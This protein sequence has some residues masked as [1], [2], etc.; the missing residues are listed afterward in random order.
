MTMTPFRGIYSLIPPQ[1][2]KKKYKP[3]LS[4]RLFKFIQ[5]AQDSVQRGIFLKTE[6]N[7]QVLLDEMKFFCS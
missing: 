2:D 3:N 5:L 4:K 7:F 1:Q 6:M